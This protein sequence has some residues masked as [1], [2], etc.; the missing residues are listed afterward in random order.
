[1]N[2]VR[3]LLPVAVLASVLGAGAP[4]LAQNIMDEWA[5]VQIPPAP[6]LDNVTV[7]S[8]TTALL[9]LDF[10]KPNCAPNPRCMATLPAVQKLLAAARDKQMFV[11]YT[12]FPIPGPTPAETLAQVAPVGKEPLVTA[13][14]DK[15]LNTN[16]DKIL[17]GNGIKTVI[18]VGSASNGAVLF[19][20]SSAFAR[21]YHVIVPVDGLSGNN[22]YVDQSVVYDFVTAPVMG[23][24][25]ALTKT[26]MIAIQ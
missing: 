1:M 13:F 25:V 11:V 21:G 16:L 23:G 19:T 10:L 18:V 15:F 12:K 5:T 2:L 24:K 26:D 9:M 8:K 14:L 7:D 4:A 22:A 17:K 6:K 20:A 3:R